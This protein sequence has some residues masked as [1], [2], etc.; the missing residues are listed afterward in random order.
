M[1]NTEAGGFCRSDSARAGQLLYFYLKSK[2]VNIEDQLRQV[3]KPAEPADS[4]LGEENKLPRCPVAS[5]PFPSP[6]LKA[7]PPVC[8]NEKNFSV[9]SF[10]L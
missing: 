9:G 4:P 3:S 1:F 2:N 10:V 8:W 6:R 7:F 5:Q